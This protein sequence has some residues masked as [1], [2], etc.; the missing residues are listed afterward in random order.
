MSVLYSSLVTQTAMRVDV[1]R[2]EKVP[3][4]ETSYR[5]RPMTRAEILVGDFTLSMVQDAVLLAEE[6]FVRAIA[7]NP[8]Q[9]MRSYL[10]DL[11]DPLASGAAIPSVSATGKSIIGVPGIIYDAATGALLTWVSPDAI[12]RFIRGTARYKTA[13]LNFSIV[14]ATLLHTVATAI[15]EVCAYDRDVQA[16]ALIANDQM[17]LPDVLEP[18][19]IDQ[20]T[21]Y[22]VRGELGVAA[23]VRYTAYGKDV[24]AEIEAGLVPGEERA[25]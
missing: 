11:T 22:L 12:N 23:S 15:M 20:A 4:L 25:A 5:V 14:G 19:I 13:I 3:E 18:A 7:N 9:P 2:G 10:R 6:F 16:A 24:L 17:L 8:K 21:T 1:L